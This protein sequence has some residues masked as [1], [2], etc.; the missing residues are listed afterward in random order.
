MVILPWL[1]QSVTFENVRDGS[2]VS[3]RLPNLAVYLRGNINVELTGAILH[4]RP[5][6]PEKYGLFV[7]STKR[8]AVI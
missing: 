7:L 4:T 2:E 1:V 3:K 6:P 5:T 8:F